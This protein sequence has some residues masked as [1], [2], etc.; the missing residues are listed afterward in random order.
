MKTTMTMKLGATTILGSAVSSAA[1]HFEDRVVVCMGLS[2]AH[3]RR[4]RRPVD[5]RRN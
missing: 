3:R 2:T 4:D 5:G 1:N